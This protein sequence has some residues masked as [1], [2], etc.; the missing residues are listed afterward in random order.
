[1][2]YLPEKVRW[3]FNYYKHTGNFLT[4]LKTVTKKKGWTM[5]FRKVVKR[6]AGGIFA[7]LLSIGMVTNTANAYDYN[8][9]GKAAKKAAE[10]K[11]INLD[12]GGEYHAYMLITAQESWVY[13]S[14]FFEKGQ[15]VDFENYNQLVTSLNGADNA[16]LGG[17]FEDAV[18]AGNGH[19]TLKLTGIAGKLSTGAESTAALGILGFTTDIPYD[20]GITFDNV[21]VKIDG[22][23][24]GTRSGSDVYYDKDDL[25]EPGLCTV[26]LVNDWHEE[27]KN[28][29]AL[30]LAQDT[31]EI[32]FD[33]SGFNYDNPNAVKQEEAP[34]EIPAANSAEQ[35][36][37]D[38][39]NDSFPVLPIVGGLVVIIIVAGIIIYVR[40]K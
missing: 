13:R 21:N 40:K 33:V 26:E 29:L 20:Q 35:G 7:V 12:E 31:I 37:S 19:Y 17:S 2:M 15:G 34:T 38:A 32:S 18:I 28:P 22:M 9:Q 36:K 6:C 39:G 24:K 3:Y 23:D 8:E 5:I 10:N 16:P 14:R 27:C 30:S 1:M 4:M 11:E 25:L